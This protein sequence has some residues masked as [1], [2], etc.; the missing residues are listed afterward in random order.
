[1]QRNSQ[2]G[3]GIKFIINITTMVRNKV[4]LRV[5]AS[6]FHVNTQTRRSRRRFDTLP[7]DE[8][9]RAVVTTAQTH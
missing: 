8:P 5:T 1:M 3:K 4:G 7:T 6:L 2:E 9:A